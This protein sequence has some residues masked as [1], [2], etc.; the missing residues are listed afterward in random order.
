MALALIDAGGGGGTKTTKTTSKLSAADYLM[1]Q[2]QA[3][4]LAAMASTA[5][6]KSTTVT[7][8]PAA[9]TTPKVTTTTTVKGA[10]AQPAYVPT[11][12]PTP[13]NN[14]QPPAARPLATA[15]IQPQ[16]KPTTYIADS[17][18]A[19]IER[20][21]GNMQGLPSPGTTGME[22]IN[23]FLLQNKRTPT[24]T[25]NP[26]VSSTAQQHSATTVRDYSQQSPLSYSDR[27]TIEGVIALMNPN[28]ANNIPT[29]VRQAPTA[30]VS[31]FGSDHIGPGGL[32]D[33]WTNTPGYVAAQQRSQERHAVDVG[34]TAQ[35]QL[36][37]WQSPQPNA[38]LGQLAGNLLGN[39]AG[40]AGAISRNVQRAPGIGAAFEV[41]GDY[42]GDLLDFVFAAPAQ[43]VV[44]TPIPGINTSA[45]E[46][47]A[48]TWD[49][50]A[51]APDVSIEKGVS[52]TQAL[53][54][55]WSNFFANQ[56]A[57]QEVRQNLSYMT[58]EARRVASVGLL[59]IPSGAEATMSA[60]VAI[61]QQQTEV[62]TMRK[63]A[64]A[65][66]LIANDPTADLTGE[67]RRFFGVQAANLG[68]EAVRLADQTPLALAEQYQ[69]WWRQLGAEALLDPFN[70]VGPVVDLLQLG[71]EARR[72]RQAQNIVD[73][74]D[75]AELAKAFE[76]TMLAKSTGL[77]GSKANT[78]IQNVLPFR[79][80]PE[81]RAI[82]AADQWFRTLG[83]VFGAVDNSTDAQ[84]LVRVLTENPV[85]LI[86]GVRGLVS[87]RIVNA[88]G[89]AGA[90][91]IGEGA[92]ANRDVINNIDALVNAAE[93]LKAL[94]SLQAQKF[95]VIEFL[96]DATD[97]IWDSAKEIHGVKQTA[98]PL[99][100]IDSLQRAFMSEVWLNMR[101][102]HWVRN[103]ASAAGHLT[104]D[105]IMTFA[106]TDWLVNNLRNK[107]G[108]VMPSI[109][110]GEAVEDVSMGRTISAVSG[111]ESAGSSM[112]RR[113]PVVGKPIAA[114][115]DFGAS[116]WS[117]NR[118]FFDRLPI[119]E[120]N[121]YIRA[122]SVP[123]QRHFERLWNQR[124]VSELM[125]ALTG[126]GIDPAL[127]GQLADV[128]RETAKYGSRDDVVHAFR[129]ALDGSY[130]PFSLRNFGIVDPA[131]SDDGYHGLVNAVRSIQD[132][133]QLRTEINR[134]FDAE[135]TMYDELLRDAPPQM[136]RYVFTQMEDVQDGAEYMTN[137]ERA[138]KRLKIPVK[139]A[140]ADAQQAVER[141]RKALDTAMSALREEAV[142]AGNSDSFNIALD[143]FAQLSS[144]RQRIRQDLRTWASRVIDG[145]D[146]YSWADYFRDARQ[147][148]DSYP[149]TVQHI[150][151]QARL[152][153]QKGET[154]RRDTVWAYLERSAQRVDDQ[155]AA[156]RGLQPGK[157]GDPRMAKVIEASQL[158]VDSYYARA[159]TAFS[160]WPTQDSLDIMMSAERDL[161]RLGSQ[162]AAYVDGLRQEMLADV[163]PLEEFYS[164][165]NQTWFDLAEAQATRLRVAVREMA[166][167]GMA[168]DAINNLRYVT[169][170][171]QQ[172][173]I[174]NYT[175]DGYTVRN[176]ET[177]AVRLTNNLPRE[178]ENAYIEAM[179]QL[180]SGTDE[181]VQMFGDIPQSIGDGGRF[182]P[183]GDDM[184]K[185][186]METSRGRASSGVTWTPETGDMA[187]YYRD[188]QE[189]ARRIL[190]DNVDRI[191][192]PGEKVITD[193]QRLRA[194][195]AMGGMMPVWDN[196]TETAARGARSVADFAM[197]DFGRRRNVDKWVSLFVP[198]HYWFTRSAGNWME[199]T[200]TKPSILSQY[201]RINREMD[202][203][204]QGLPQRL[205]GTIPVADMGDETLR[206]ANPLRYI[207]PYDIYAGNSWAEPDEANSQLERWIETSKI[208]G[209]GLLPV[210]DAAYQTWRG[211]GETI[212]L[213]D[214]VPQYRSLN[215]L[216][217]TITG[218]SLPSA[219]DEFDQ[220]RVAR[221][222]ALNVF[223]GQID[224]S[225]GQFAQDVAYQVLKDVGPLPEEPKQAR[226]VYEQAAKKA[227]F[228]RGMA[229][230]GAFL[231]G[232][233]FYMSTDTEQQARDVAELYRLVGW[234]PD[235]N[236]TGAKA[237]RKD[238]LEENPALSAWWAKSD[239]V[240]QQG[241]TAGP[242][243]PGYPFKQ[244]AQ[245][246]GRPGVSA[247]T[248]MLYGQLN[249]VYQQRQQ[250]VDL[251]LTNFP[252]AKYRDVAKIRAKFDDQIAEVDARLDQVNK[253]YPTSFDSY[254][255][256]NPY[257]TAVEATEQAVKLAKAKLEAQ[258]PTSPG[259]G[260]TSAQWEQ[261]FKER[262]A[263]DQMLA[264]LVEKYTASPK[265]LS[266]IANGR[267]V[268]EAAYDVAVQGRDAAAL[269]KE[270]NQRNMSE[271]EK[272]WDDR[273]QTTSSRYYTPRRY[274]RTS[275]GG[276]YG[277]GSSSSVPRFNM[278][279]DARVNSM[280]NRR[281]N[282][283]RP[284]A[285]RPPSLPG[286]LMQFANQL[287]PSGNLPQ[288]R[289]PRVY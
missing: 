196:V 39:V 202:K 233:P 35:E 71:T 282:N 182:M 48:S 174:I 124:V 172:W 50:L 145:E 243:P 82:I 87:P 69:T 187:G 267:P 3:L 46:L 223:R 195:D 17:D 225:M 61:Q 283:N 36:P 206:V 284:T 277:G 167:D 228:D 73:A 134:I 96:A 192:N 153:L 278:P 148:W 260:A 179:A 90:L 159:Y 266:E 89:E 65:F 10:P 259:D 166:A 2:E 207:I 130:Q 215:Y 150:T 51:D 108:G 194:L 72:L 256:M 129:R 99:R 289:Q 93:R 240:P 114:F 247:L 261:Y 227:G 4:K 235:Q 161:S 122:F 201:L 102:G 28:P 147:R 12:Q 263:Y 104:T 44:T 66:Y 107:F 132:P 279:Y 58:P 80:T 142:R 118:S 103:A 252:N 173:R 94:P 190:L 222:I 31:P 213:G 53:T 85:Q 189:H 218:D 136:G 203:E 60:V 88:V 286:S 101:P 26:F 109:R 27:N 198:Y 128:V 158:Y 237:A 214:F 77:V 83:T 270:Y 185:V 226:A 84:A 67:Q 212:Q 137:M 264:D 176:V 208:F 38:T 19:T 211:K 188:T 127:A 204:N 224:P 70:L 15:T 40:Q 168:Q 100:K 262:A 74:A 163:L 183:D 37:E 125:P 288:Y 178:V 238:I 13:A 245:G 42:G 209:F 141:V 229:I 81:S 275:A 273:Q 135:A 239:L 200:M 255:G 92:L 33:W 55:A 123:F 79:L 95:N 52:P 115:S 265:A 221:E 234:T 152:A 47:L 43:A 76:K 30:P 271:I 110:L 21:V 155:I 230:V 249:S 75:R 131:L 246:P 157:P 105:Q 164:L 251:Y 45:G 253:Q 287:R 7:A 143:A 165:R 242:V 11:A 22:Y 220:Y 231:T 121:F 154:V 177:G 6:K 140:R 276:G 116:V 139:Q 169:P 32:F 62:D 119:G 117:G 86:E 160:R 20:I 57:F 241:S 144:E 68:A 113:I 170:D 78:F 281:F 205:Q 257:E 149:A 120:Q 98:N 5:D 1:L 216:Y 138:A 16:N 272:A 106:R 146:N 181:V 232:L 184:E 54:V 244:P 268:S 133:E 191:T 186:I 210:Y 126:A 9:T 64:E 41:I 151:D 8:K 171:G 97:A 199:R 156:Q 23:Q 18:R 274:Y 49:A 280:S 112:F 91:R 111:A 56:N 197:L 254:S 250:A 63:Q 175:P 59:N 236:P 162:A 269:I 248:D 24:Q 180:R 193:A 14:Y 219:G 258:R 285:F 217:Q 29:N 25:A 34:A